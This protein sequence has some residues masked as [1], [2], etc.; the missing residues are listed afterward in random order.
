MGI[1]K[2]HDDCLA[3][4][5]FTNGIE[6]HRRRRAVLALGRH[7]NQA[8]ATNRLLCIA[9]RRHVD[10]ALQRGANGLGRK[11]QLT[12][13]NNSGE[14]TVQVRDRVIA[15]VICV[16]RLPLMAALTHGKRMSVAVERH[17]LVIGLG[18]SETAALTMRVTKMAQMAVVILKLATTLRTSGEVAHNAL[19]I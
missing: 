15:K 11:P 6:R 4:G 13:H 19:R 1:G 14:E 10:A 18:V 2:H 7:C 5:L 12:G 17:E 3:T 16:G 9:Q 8:L